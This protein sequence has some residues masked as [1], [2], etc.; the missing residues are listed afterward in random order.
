MPSIFLSVYADTLNW[1]DVE[2][3][4]QTNS[5][6]LKR[7]RLDV[8]IA[9]KDITEGKMAYLPSIQLQANLERLED[10]A[11][12]QVNNSNPT[13]IGDAFILNRSIT[14]NSASLGI[15]Y[16]VLD[17][18]KRKSRVKSAEAQRD[19]EAYEVGGITRNLRL[20][21]M[22]VFVQIWQL[23]QEERILNRQ[24]N[25]HTQKLDYLKRLEKAG[26]L[27]KVPLYEQ[28]LQ[29]LSVQQELDQRRQRLLREYQ[30]LS[31]YTQESYA[32]NPPEFSL[33]SSNELSS[34]GLEGPSDSALPNLDTYPEIRELESR[35]AQ[36][37][38]EKR[39]VKR[40]RWSP[41]ISVYGRLIAYGSDGSS[42]RESFEDADFRNGRLG[43]Q[44]RMP[45]SQAY[46]L[47]P[48][49]EKL[50]LEQERLSLELEERKL[51]LQQ[52]WTDNEAQARNMNTFETTLANTQ[53]QV[54]QLIN[55]TE[56]LTTAKVLTPV[57]VL[58]A[59]IKREDAALAQV[60]LEA[61]R[62]AIQKKREILASAPDIPRG[63]TPP[64]VQ[65]T[66]TATP[67][68]S[69]LSPSST[70]V[71]PKKATPSL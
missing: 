59:A 56:K 69:S 39:Y 71:E 20:E 27:G 68:T 38:E 8:D 15:D 30:A 12:T 47:K 28:A 52:E 18:G 65:V 37:E 25:L 44:L 48:R 40:Q 17:F 33:A 67:A 53:T 55:A 35:I 9:K 64:A 61:Q 16:V 1:A 34:I 32:D 46:A 42:L 10:L 3:R 49:E 63:P 66:N 62:W 70:N 58:D 54:G 31:R 21:V 36:K 11:P 43:V 5:L 50:A 29:V 51:R 13:S 4:V 26:E 7:E 60:R 24:L 57:N 14:Q 6:L 41:D 2:Q 22:P 19:A 45:L 23:Q